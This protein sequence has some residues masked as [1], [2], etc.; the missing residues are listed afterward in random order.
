MIKIAI[1][2]KKVGIGGV[3]K[4]LLSMLCNINYSKICID[5]YLPTE[6]KANLIPQEIHIK[7][8]ESILSFREFTY[9]MQHPI[10][11]FNIF[12]YLFKSKLLKTTNYVDELNHSKYFYKKN[13]KKYD[14]VIS[15]DGPLGF[16]TFYSLY[17]LK[18]NK[19]KIWIHGNIIQDH[20]PKKIIKRYY[21]Q[22]DEMIFV[23]KM[24]RDEFLSYYPEYESKSRV[25][26][27]HIE[28]E[29]IQELAVQEKI[30]RLEKLMFLT[31]ARVSYEKGI[32]IALECG[33]LL[34][35]KDI[36]FVW[37]IC[38]S[39]VL[40]DEM[41]KKSNILGVAKNFVFLGEKENPYPYMEKCDIYIQP[42]R[43]EGFCTTTN[44]A[45]VLGKAIVTTDVGG[46]REQFVDHKTALIT[47]ISAQG[48]SNAVME[49]L[50]NPSLKEEM[51]YNNK[52]SNFELNTI[53]LNDILI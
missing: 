35:D 13:S 36:D 1:V 11:I 45:R 2:S 22:F 9:K 40:L 28:K 20:V 38:G 14:V 4:A 49:L 10:Q 52:N 3:E 37:Y 21:S 42:S 16:S 15:Y 6:E 30:D 7:K 8:F 23:S 33:K 39:G 17:N 44:E 31:V 43:T 29:K 19:K 34:K 48:L 5:L 24:I 53:S 41:Q 47:E 46:M 18:A 50:N 51:E 25:Y 32:D 27:N 12:F 26:Y